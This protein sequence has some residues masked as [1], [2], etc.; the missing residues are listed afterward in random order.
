MR[1]SVKNATES[2]ELLATEPQHGSNMVVALN[3]LKNKD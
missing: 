1:P 3:H 2:T